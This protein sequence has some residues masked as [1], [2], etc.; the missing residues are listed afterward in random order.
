[1]KKD[2]EI[3][4]IRRERLQYLIDQ[5]FH[6]VAAFAEKL[7]IH[8]ST[9]STLLKGMRDFTDFTATKIESTFALPEGYLSSEEDQRYILT[10]FVDVK[11]HEDI[12]YISNPLLEKI[13]KV[14]S[15]ICNQ[16]NIQKAESLIATKMNDEL[17]YPTINKDELIVIDTSQ[18]NIEENKIYLFEIN[19]LFKIRRLVS[20]GKDL[21]AL[22]ID[23]ENEKKKYIINS[24]PLSDI[25][26]LGRVVG[27]IKNYN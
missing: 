25:K 11:F 22:H 10:D 16:F 1:M 12:K 3:Q 26:T 8:K 7:G 17:M 14:P 21:V 20:T 18:A 2:E 5:K 24:M 13:I 6:T 27:G 9:V 23:N 15:L 19:G 4:V